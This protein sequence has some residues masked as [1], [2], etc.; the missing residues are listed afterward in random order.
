[1][2]APQKA[3]GSSPIGVL[4]AKDINLYFK[5]RFITF[6][7]ILALVAFIV[8]YFLLLRTLDEVG[9]GVYAPVMPPTLAAILAEEG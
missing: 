9:F 7:T 8:V 4:I 3:A 6:V 2:T 1:M 5:D